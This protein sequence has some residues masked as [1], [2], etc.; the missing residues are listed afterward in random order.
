ME[1][2]ERVHLARSVWRPAKPP[3]AANLSANRLPTAPQ[4]TGQLDL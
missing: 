1:C 3:P 2:G 4:S